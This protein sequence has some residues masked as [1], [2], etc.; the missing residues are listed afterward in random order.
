MV[1]AR[2]ERSELAGADPLLTAHLVRRVATCVILT[3]VAK[4][5]KDARNIVVDDVRYRWRATGND[6]WISLTVWPR[7]LPG[8]PIACSFSYDQTSVLL[9]NG[10]SALLHQIVITN[11]IVRR[12]IEHA[13]RVFAYDAHTKGKQLT[14]RKVDKAIDMSDAPRSA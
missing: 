1:E 9:G 3:A 12:V 7:D 5:R 10:A 8:P 4:A 6:G 14:L 11:R 13:T 2:R